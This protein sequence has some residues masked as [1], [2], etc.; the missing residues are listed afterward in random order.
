ML[1]RFGDRWGIPVAYCNDYGHGIN[2]AILPIG[3][4]A[5]FDSE[6][7]SL[8]FLDGAGVSE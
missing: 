4:K 1:G 2:H 3:G 7:H 8:R 6:S 5:V